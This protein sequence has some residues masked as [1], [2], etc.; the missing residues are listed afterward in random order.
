MEWTK[1]E[2]KWHEM[3]L[4]LQSARGTGETEKSDT[5]AATMGAQA[6]GTGQSGV[7]GDAA[8]GDGNA[9]FVRELA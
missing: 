9:P 2:K 3:A 7:S 1:I 6:A 4:R 5:L 8:S